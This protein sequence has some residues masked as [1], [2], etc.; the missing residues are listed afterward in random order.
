MLGFSDQLS[1]IEVLSH[2][3][4]ADKLGTFRIFLLPDLHVSLLRES[5]SAVF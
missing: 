3:V 1:I 5:G 2:F 4:V